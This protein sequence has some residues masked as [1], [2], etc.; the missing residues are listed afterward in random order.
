MIPG[1][2]CEHCSKREKCIEANEHGIVC[3]SFSEDWKAIEEDP[4]L[5]RQWRAE[6]RRMIRRA[7]KEIEE[8][9][10]QYKAKG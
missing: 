10:A 4:A 5:Q 6:R 3:R 8:M 9:N 1:V 2:T 7:K